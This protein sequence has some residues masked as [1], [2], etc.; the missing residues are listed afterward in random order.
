ML[1]GCQLCTSDYEVLE[2]GKSIEKLVQSQDN[3]RAIPQIDF[4]WNTNLYDFAYLRHYFALL[5]RDGSGVDIV[6]PNRN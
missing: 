1:R 6:A 5:Y 2:L 3:V 4:S